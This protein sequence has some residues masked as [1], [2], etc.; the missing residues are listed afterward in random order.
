MR[1]EQ[2]NLVRT[3]RSNKIVRNEVKQLMRQFV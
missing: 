3:S 2:I 1:A